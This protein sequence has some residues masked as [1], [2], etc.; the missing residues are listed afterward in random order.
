MV[1]LGV[2]PPHSTLHAAMR[3]GPRTT[4]ELVDRY[5]IADQQI[6]ELLIR[7]LDERR[8]ALDYST[9][10]M[11]V[12]HL[13]GAFWAD[14]ERHHPGVDTLN[15]PREVTDAWKERLRFPQNGGSRPTQQR[16]IDILITVRALLPRHRRMGAVRPVLGT[17]GVPQSGA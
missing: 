13:A 16:H 15:L 8:P 6:R 11:L 14:I 7:Y 3:T 1:D 9:F 2:F 17:L 4:A 5:G 10:R 12:G